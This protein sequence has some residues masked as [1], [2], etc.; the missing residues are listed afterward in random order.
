MQYLL[1]IDI[2]TSGTKT[3]IF[4]TAGRTIAGATFEYGLSQ[5]K[6]G[7]AEQ[8]PEDW[9]EATVKGIS[10][11]IG[12]SGIRAEDIVGI[13]LSGQMHG[14]VMLDE[15]DEVIRPAIIWCDQRTQKQCDYITDV[16]GSRLIEITANP[17]LTGFTL[18]KLLWV[19][20]NEPENYAKCRHVLLPKDYVRYRLTGVFATEV[21]DAGGMQMLD[22]PNRKW[23]KEL[24]E[25]FGIDM[26]L[27]PEVYESHVV[28]GRI[29]SETA[30]ITGLAEG[31]AVVGGAGDQA[32]AAIGNGIVEEGLISDTLGTSG[33]VFATTDR[34][35]VDKLGRAHTFCHAV[36][37]KWH[38]MGVTQGAGLSLH[39][40]RDNFCFSEQSEAERNNVDVYKIMD[41]EAAKIPAGCDGAIYLPYLM[42][43]RTPHLN[44]NAKAVFY[45]MTAAHNRAHMIRAVME[46]VTYSQR[47]C[48]GIIN[49]LGIVASQ[50]RVGGGGAKSKLWKQMLAD[51]FGTD[52]A[53]VNSTEGGALGVAILAGVGVGIFP[54]VVT[55]CRD[56]IKVSSITKPNPETRDIYGKTYDCY[57]AIYK[58]LENLMKA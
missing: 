31:T 58:S 53:V 28:S 43:E 11:A 29:T 38:V 48:L 44:P 17:A 34:P 55:A 25:A 15:N 37:G 20:E 1:G 54:D 14:L 18:S 16:M 4:D 2:G 49:E 40:F 50:I 19:R 51:N 3:V 24:L 57:R 9:Y 41:D 39:W 52:I 12:K 7:W 56:I 21:S 45:G 36:E 42:G 6:I 5:P 10:S 46:G 47:D 30:R 13:G 35:L 8:N 23:S 32:A 26:D 33:V 27:L 22:V